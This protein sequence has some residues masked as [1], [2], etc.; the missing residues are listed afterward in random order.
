MRRFVRGVIAS[1]DTVARG[2]RKMMEGVK[3]PPDLVERLHLGQAT[4][5]SYIISAIALL[6]LNTIALLFVDF[7]RA[8]GALVRDTSMLAVCVCYLALIARGRGWLKR[9]Q[10]T[11]QDAKAYITVMARLLVLLG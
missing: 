8:P 11:G 2:V 7:L 9:V 3:V 5:F 6:G 4:D 1:A 10:P